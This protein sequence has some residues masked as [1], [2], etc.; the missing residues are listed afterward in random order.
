MDPSHSLQQSFPSVQ[1]W[2]FEKLA[3]AF[4]FA[5]EAGS[6]AV[7]VLHKG[8]LV[9]EWG[10]TTLRIRSNSVR[11]SLLSALYGIA[12]DKKLMDLSTTLDELGIDDRPPCLTA[13][14][15]QATI[16]DLLKS[17]SGIYHPAAAE[18][19][20]MKKRKPARGF[21]APGQYWYYNNWD[22]NA[23]GTIFE[24]KSNIS[25]NQ[26]FKEWIADPIGMQDFRI[27][28]V[29]Y[30]WEP[31]SIHPAYHFWISPRDLARFG[32]LYLQ[33]G[34]WKN[35]QVI[36]ASWVDE[37]TVSH[38]KTSNGGYGYMWWI[39]PDSSYYA[40]GFM[41]QKILIIPKH[42]IV[43]VNSVFTG[44]RSFPYLSPETMEEL[45]HFIS[46]VDPHEFRQLVEL[47]L[48]AAP[49]ESFSSY[50]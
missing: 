21:Y 31:T 10:K 28:D 25:I 8:Q 15:K 19:S 7:V 6:T 20:G 42:E 17:R 1:A 34:L 27:Q 33:K 30:K 9:A 40:S 23:L 43:I 32:Q 41:G 44:T 39:N 26:A 12:V 36:P 13:K 11:K 48:E 14:E 22:F 16:A 50:P 37:S 45:R 49:P 2:S 38:S 3:R 18:S 24:R 35:T 5:E 4:Y 29:E 47:I 46:P